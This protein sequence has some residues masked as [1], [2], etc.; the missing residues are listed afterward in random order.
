MKKLFIILIVVIAS[1]QL[2]AQVAINTTGANPDVSA[3]L[4][5]SYTNK[6]L[7]I[8]R[9]ALTAT[10]DATTIATPAT[11][12]L[13]Y[14]LGT[15]G[16]APAGYYYNAGTT[17]LPNWVRFLNSKE[18]WLL[19]GNAGTTAGTDF[20]G[21]TDAQDLV[22]K[23]NNINR[24]VVKQSAVNYP[25][26]GIGTMFPVTNLDGTAGVLHL[27]DGGTGNP[28]QLILG[29]HS[30]TAGVKI[31]SLYFA[32]TQATNDRRTGSIE[33]YLTAYSGG[34]CTGDLRFLTNNNNTYSEKMRVMGNGNVG[35]NTTAPAT[36]LQVVG[37]TTI[38]RDGSVECCGNDATLAL[39]DNPATTGRA[40]I[41]FHNSGEA[42][43]TLRLIQNTVNGV[44][45]RR[46]QMY[47]NQGVYMGLELTGRLWYGNGNSR[48]ESRDDAG[49][50]GNVGA[51]SGFFET[52]SP[53]NYPA[54]ASSWWHLIDTRHSNSGNNYALQIAGSF[55]DQDLY[56]RK[57]NN[58]PAQ[59]WRYLVSANNAGNS[60]QILISQ[61]AG[62]PAI[63]QS[64][65]SVIK[66]YSA[67]ATRTSISGTTWIDVAGLSVNVTTTGA[68]KLIIMTY[69]SL[70]VQSSGG[71]SGCEIRILQNGST[72]PNAFQTIDINDG[73]YTVGTI[74]IWS[75]Q[76]VVNIAAAGTYTFKIQA[77]EYDSSFDNFYAGGNTT[78]PAGS[79]NQG[80][81]IILQFDQ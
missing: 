81:L 51:Q 59:P 47:D 50:Q 17:V 11:S 63:W 14:N 13:V 38:S 49:L 79:Q 53:T 68:A 76:T 34:N 36:R 26:V 7:L 8:P 80:A 29:T 1:G 72:I 15:G 70:E 9:V 2:M 33:S 48:T 60:G 21:T 6:G 20:L 55:F 65:N 71:N 32:A 44:N 18:A 66:S 56:F 19:A 40:S 43:G 78:A 54:G 67:F 30:T 42:E 52:A 74:G 27:H 31:G 39:A 4:D 5:I 64:P 62:N 61:G 58:N 57:T 28:V 10:T 73:Y 37:K 77:H 45:S 3:G 25:I 12:T 75:F 35:I 23:T 41:S 16:L 22:I 69:G 46:F 24:I